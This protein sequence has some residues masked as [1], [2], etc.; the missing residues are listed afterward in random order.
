MLVKSSAPSSHPP[1]PGT[2]SAL[3]SSCIVTAPWPGVTRDPASRA[4]KGHSIT[5]IPR[6]LENLLEM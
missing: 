6:L 3:V 5:C 1:G 2:T 4:S